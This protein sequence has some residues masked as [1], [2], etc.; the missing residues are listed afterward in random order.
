[1]RVKGKQARGQPEGQHG[2]VR[3]VKGH[4][5]LLEVVSVALGYPAAK[6]KSEIESVTRF[7]VRP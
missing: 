6:M 5:Q 4:V 1:M 2:A 3:T 7:R